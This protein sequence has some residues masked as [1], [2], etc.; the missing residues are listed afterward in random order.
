[1]RITLPSSLLALVSAIATVLAL[2]AFD[3]GD[4]VPV[5]AGEDARS[6]VR[7][8]LIVNF[9]RGF[10]PVRADIASVPGASVKRI[11]TGGRFASVSVPVGA[12]DRFVGLLE[13]IPGIASVE[14][15]PIKH[16]AFIPND[17][18]YDLQWNMPLIQA[19]AAWNISMGDGVTVAVL[20]TG[21][22]F[23]GVNLFGTDHSQ[24]PDLAG[25]T[26]VDPYDAVNGGD[27]PVDEDGHGTH[28]TGTIVQST[29]NGIG[30]AG[31]APDARVIPVKVCSFVGCPGFAIADGIIWAVDHG[32]D[33]INMSLGGF[34]I[35]QAERDALQ[36]A[37]DH[38]VLVVAAAGN[39]GADKK[40]DGYLDYPAAVATVFS[41]AAIRYD[42]QKAP[43][44]NYGL[45]DGAGLDIVAPGGDLSVDQNSDGYSDGVLQNTF[46]FRCGSAP[47]GDYTAFDY[48]YY[49][50]TSMAT[51]HVS[52][53][54]A[55]LLSEHPDLTPPEVREVLRCSALDLGA[56]AYDPLFGAGLVQA[57][58]ALS[59][60]DK[61][62]I[63]DCLDES[64]DPEPPFVSI[65]SATAQSGEE[66]TVSL[67]ANV[68]EPGLA[69][70][71]I[72]VTFDPA[73]I[74]PV[75]CNTESTAVCNLNYGGAGNT[76]RVAGA[77][78]DP[79]LGPVEI[80]QISFLAVTETHSSTPLDIELVGFAND[81]LVDL[82]PETAVLDGEIIVEAPH[83]L[84]GD[85][86]CD[87]DVDV[88]DLLGILQFAAGMK[89]PGCIGAGDVDCDGDVDAVDALKLAQYLAAIPYTVPAGCPPIGVSG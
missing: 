65:A 23:E 28:V 82:I 6:T 77:A 40:G 12:E 45:G 49:Q 4:A 39:G 55:L 81:D 42:K 71:A 17:E 33:I 37:E 38:G 52:G 76:V 10:P 13:A 48:C 24:A 51:P 59:D 50:G 34:S 88:L 74:Q 18:L 31:V 26:F 5:R 2:A 87:G 84:L 70:F 11:A 22:A 43:Y 57:A 60:L 56:P 80:A 54:A 7:G 47:F 35:S 64:P 78:L 75:S 20:D 19:E 21:I 61:D 41:V 36:Y 58:D 68:D 79:L 32:A 69:A 14:R 46:G 44:S 9:Q 89:L 67:T 72:N 25:T 1:M 16:A 66:V 73:V 83:L 8:E 53:A 3:G 86:D 62:G 63:V 85:V 30:V 29:D 27:H 15:N